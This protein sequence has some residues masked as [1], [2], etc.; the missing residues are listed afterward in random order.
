MRRRKRRKCLYCIGEVA[1]NDLRL[2]R[3]DLGFYAIGLHQESGLELAWA[4]FAS[5]R[6]R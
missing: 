5:F 1:G 4:F 6:P 3:S 2:C